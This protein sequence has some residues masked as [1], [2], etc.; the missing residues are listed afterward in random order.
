MEETKPG[1]GLAAVGMGRQPSGQNEVPHLIEEEKQQGTG[2]AMIVALALAVVVS[3][4]TRAVDL[5]RQSP[6]LDEITNW[7]IAVERGF[8]WR[9]GGHQLTYLSIRAGLMLSDSEWGLRLYSALFGIGAVL[10]A[11][12]WG[13]ARLGVVGGIAAALLLGLSPMAIFYSEDANHYAPL[14]LAGLLSTIAVDFAGARDRP[15]WWV[16]LAAL[17]LCGVSVL[18]HPLGLMT[19]AALG[20]TAL[21]WAFVYTEKIPPTSW[22][23]SRK[24]RA[25]AAVL[26][27][28]VVAALPIVLRRFLN[29][30]NAPATEGRVF[31]LSWDFWSAMLGAFYGAIHHFRG[32]DTA[33]GVCGVAL[34]AWGWWIA[35]RTPERRFAA[36]GAA[37]TLVAVFGLFLL[38]SVRQY[39]SPRYVAAGLAPALLGMAVLAACGGRTSRVIL[40]CWL[41]VFAGRSAWWGW[42]RT[43][44]DF[45]PARAA[46]EW[47]AEN[48]PEDAIILT[49]HRYSALGFEFLSEREGI[50]GREHRPLSYLHRRGGPSIQQ[51]EELLFESRRPVYFLS[52]IEDEE[53]L[54]PDWARW[55]EANGPVVATL[56]SNA[57]DAFVPID[58]S[59][60]IRRLARPEEDPLAL[61]RFGGRPSTLWPE[62]HITIPAWQ[63]ESAI[64]LTEGTG[65]S[66]KFR[67]DEPIEVVTI[68]LRNLLKETDTSAIA[69]IDNAAPFVVPLEGG[70]EAAFYLPQI[71]EP[72][73]H[74]LFFF[75]P[76]DGNTRHQVEFLR[77]DAGILEDARVVLPT[78]AVGVAEQGMN[79]DGEVLFSRHETR[80]IVTELLPIARGP[81]PIVFT[82][83]LHTT[84]TGDHAVYTGFR[85]AAGLYRGVHRLIDWTYSPAMV[86]IFSLDQEEEIAVRTYLS[87]QMGF[88]PRG[89][90]L[91]L[92]PIEAWRVMIE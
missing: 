46:V 23:V 71:L 66:W 85:N 36:V 82:R 7:Q 78:Y 90:T 73:M 12:A 50:E 60:R 37:M 38:I 80:E 57:P 83:S 77:L 15:R 64:R 34:S 29:L 91:E 72:G 86:G 35:A 81:L 14:I 51:A 68:T 2:R 40:V 17:F 42:E 32:I 67:I 22:S 58:W 8:D 74:E 87:E 33:L 19:V 65:A 53:L 21:I 45:Q 62:D 3:L 6:W 26:A 55:I 69:R 89:G 31:G 1:K 59:I 5:G 9:P 24:R 47:I 41:A 56:E 54:A 61:P 52:L 30:W 92:G 84:G 76:S 75:V 63:R 70:D 28:C 79:F 11:A 44:G 13:A 39:F 49:R 48:T 88:R 4:A 18:Y 10:L 43:E 16:V 27:L 20:M 25:M